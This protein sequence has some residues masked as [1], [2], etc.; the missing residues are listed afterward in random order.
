MSQDVDIQLK[1]WKDLAIS[2]QILM[3]AAADALG[4]DA[5][6]SSEE[7]KTA[8][9][10][11]IQRARDADINIQETRSEAERQVAEFR[12]QTKAAEEAR[13]EAESKVESAVKAQAQAERQLAAGKADNA[14]ALRRARAEVNDKQSQLKSISKAL[15]DTPENVVP[16]LKTLKKQKLDEAK[17]RDQAEASLQRTRKKLAKLEAELETQKPVMEQVGDLLEQ[18]KALHELC[19][20]ADTTIEKLKGK[21]KDRLKIPELDQNAIDTLE[22]ALST[23]S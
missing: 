5:E 3:G 18:V 14:E 7:L 1:V 20:Q 9:N 4:L 17:G 12:Q 10:K 13:I 8:L 11:A 16:K 19:R 15:A 2:K 21:K 23:K 6:C 22:Q